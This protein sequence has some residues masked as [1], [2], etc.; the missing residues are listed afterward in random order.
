ME[1]VEDIGHLQLLHQCRF[2]ISEGIVKF[3]MQK[4]STKVVT[5]IDSSSGFKYILWPK[6]MWTPQHRLNTTAVLQKPWAARYTPP[7]GICSATRTLVRSNSQLSLH[8]N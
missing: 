1:K 7:P 3:K 2:L 8:P 5:S 6:D 4:K